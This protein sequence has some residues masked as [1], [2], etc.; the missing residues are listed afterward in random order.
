MSVSELSTAPNKERLRLLARYWL[1]LLLI[2]TLGCGGSDLTGPTGASASSGTGSSAPVNI[3]GAYTLTLTASA[4][5]TQL[6]A[7]ARTRQYAATITQAGSAATVNLSGGGLLDYQVSAQ[8]F[9]SSAT[10]LIV[11]G[12]VNYSTGEGLVING[13][14]TVQ[15]SS[16]PSVI[17]GD[18]NGQFQYVGLT[19]RSCGAANHR[20]SFARR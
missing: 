6:P 17:A 19:D 13:T 11:T 18:L 4:V 12:D 10:F 20:F 9:G 7:S 16:S 15:V 3:A 5:C 14:A 8:I 1:V 2:P